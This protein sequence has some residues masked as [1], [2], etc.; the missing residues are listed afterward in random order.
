MRMGRVRDDDGKC[1][2]ASRW[3]G[4]M[5]NE[6][7]TGVKKVYGR[8]DEKLY[9]WVNTRTGGQMEYGRLVH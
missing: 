3:V 1:V 9:R 5:M 2:H 6:Y 7:R 8:V 4:R